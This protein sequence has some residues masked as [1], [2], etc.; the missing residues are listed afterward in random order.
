MD[1]FRIF[2]SYPRWWA[3]TVLCVSLALLADVATA[4]AADVEAR[5]FS[6]TVDG[7]AAGNYHMVIQRRDDGS[8]V[9]GAQADVTL[10]YVVISYNYKYRGTEVWKDGRLLQLDSATDDDGKKYTVNAVA[11]G[12][13]LRVKANGYERL[14]KADV[15]LSTYWKLP[16]AKYRNA[17]VP[18]IDADTGRD[19]NATLQL[20]GN[21][22][23]KVAGQSVSAAHYRLA[24]D[25][26]VDLWYDA[27]ERMLRQD[28]LEDGHR[29]VLELTRLRR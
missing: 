17:A 12:N 16:D 5:D 20:V 14:A 7:K 22:Q 18:L 9:M 2:P 6:V 11:E 26:K 10:K 25:V 29:T 4:H 19:L 24:G 28:S 23:I 1:G 27:Q 8:F 3:T 15:W 13:G 21:E